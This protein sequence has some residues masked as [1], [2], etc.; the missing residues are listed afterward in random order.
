MRS[1]V[2]GLACLVLCA[3]SVRAAEP[4]RWEYLVLPQADLLA[5]AAPAA[6]NKFQSALNVLGADGWELVAI[7]P[8]PEKDRGNRPGPAGGPVPQYIFKR[9]K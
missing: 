2:L 4:I 9:K 7:D 8:Q 1:L 5:K 3:G 6:A